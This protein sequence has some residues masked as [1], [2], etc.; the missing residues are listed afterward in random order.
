M[1]LAD[2]D[3]S[4]LALACSSTFP[5]VRSCVVLSAVSF[6]YLFLSL[7]LSLG[8]AV[9]AG[10]PLVNIRLKQAFS[11][12][13]LHPLCGLAQASSLLSRKF[14]P[15]VLASHSKVSLQT[16]LQQWE[17]SFGT[18]GLAMSRSLPQ[19]VR[20]SKMRYRILPLTP[21][22]VSRHHLGCILGNTVPQILLGFR[23]RHPACARRTSVRGQA[24]LQRHA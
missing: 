22:F 13:E 20:N 10:Q 3:K 24:D 14:A 11:L 16:Q 6:F 4:H 2:T 18:N 19:S 5:F 1:T 9:L 7:F 21:M 12:L 8:R 17:N 23:R 15:L